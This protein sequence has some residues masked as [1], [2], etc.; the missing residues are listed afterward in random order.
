MACK[1]YKS[2]F[3]V[4]SYTVL[5]QYPSAFLIEELKTKYVVLIKVKAIA[6]D[7]KK[8]DWLSLIQNFLFNKFWDFLNSN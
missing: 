5:Q 2:Y 7:S 6:E 1:Y 3:S 8:I 4:K